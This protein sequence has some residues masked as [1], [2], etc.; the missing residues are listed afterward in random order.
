MVS[1]G[2]RFEDD[3]L[4]FLN[5]MTPSTTA[6]IENE[7]HQLGSLKVSLVLTAELKKAAPYDEYEILTRAYFRSTASPILK[8]GVIAQKLADATNQIMGKLE[9]FTKEGS[10]WRLNRCEFLD[11]HFA[12][13]QPFRGR[14]Y[15]KTPTY[16]PPRTVINVKN[17]DNRCFEWAILSALY[18]VAHGQHPYRLAGYQAHRGGLNFAGIG[19]PV[20][21][22]DVTKFER[23][24]PTLSVNVFGWKSGPIPIHVS[25]QVGIEIDLLLLTDVKDPQKTHYVWIKDLARM[26]YKNSNYEGRKHPCFTVFTDH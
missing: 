10:G 17:Q 9:K 2:H 6:Q 18:P 25:K 12:R 20:K 4:A 16:I 5:V 24:I 14:S 15:I 19:F 26:L 3:A 7:L 23:Q 1:I 8:P 13:Y 22:T 11:L 21:V